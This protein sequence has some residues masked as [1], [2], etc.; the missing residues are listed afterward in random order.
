MTINLSDAINGLI[1]FARLL[2]FD[3]VLFTRIKVK[4]IAAFLFLD[5]FIY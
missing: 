5:R 2:N 3:S 1:A 4:L